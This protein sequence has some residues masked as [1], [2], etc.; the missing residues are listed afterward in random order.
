MPRLPVAFVT[1]CR[2]TLTGS[3]SCETSEYRFRHQM[4]LSFF[5]GF[6]MMER[7]R[8]ASHFKATTYHDASKTPEAGPNSGV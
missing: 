2:G 7:G 5:E 3:R 8:G 4:L 6:R 1:H